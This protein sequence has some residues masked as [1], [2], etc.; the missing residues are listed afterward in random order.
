[1]RP[2]P[3]ERLAEPHIRV[4]LVD[5]DEEDFLLTSDLLRE[6]EGARFELEWV[7]SFEAGLQ[8]LTTGQHAVVL[9][10]YYLGA[11]DGL[12]F[13]RERE[14]LQSRTPV[15][16]LTGQDNQDVN[17]SAIRAGAADYLVKGQIGAPLLE[18][19]ILQALERT[20]ELEAVRARGAISRRL[21]VDRSGGADFRC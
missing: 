16:L 10:D 15:I 1:M 7:E 3:G 9:V 8:R 2:N 18:R 20:R 21:R 6:A 5:D 19:S 13:L 14:R 17:L 12:E 11:H 4:L